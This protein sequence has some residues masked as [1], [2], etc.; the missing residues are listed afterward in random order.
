MCKYKNWLVCV[1]EFTDKNTI[2]DDCPNCPY[3][4]ENENKK[5]GGVNMSEDV[6][7]INEIEQPELSVDVPK[8]GE[9]TEKKHL[10][11]LSIL[12]VMFSICLMSIQIATDWLYGETYPLLPFGIL[13]SSLIAV[14]FIWKNK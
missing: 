4:P 12:F 1:D 3:Y 13:F 8:R 5:L 2:A 11:I 9:Q 10:P 7:N 14:V 6:K